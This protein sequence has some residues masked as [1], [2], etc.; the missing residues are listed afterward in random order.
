MV[1]TASLTVLR[2]EHACLTV[3]KEALEASLAT[4]EAS[5][6]EVRAELAL[7]IAAH[8]D[9]L[10][11]AETAEEKVDETTVKLNE[12]T[13]LMEEESTRSKQHVQEARERAKAE[14][15]AALAAHKDFDKAIGWQEKVI[16]MAD[17]PYQP[18]AK[19]MLDRYQA[20]QPYDADAVEKELEAD[21]EI[22]P[23]NQP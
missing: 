13:N 19:R 18:F 2:E 5:L 7:S 12:L 21:R 6:V 11:R 16:Q 3:I 1:E 4:G 15:A 17:E 20:H 8:K 23:T 9:A 10:A 22:Q 14:L